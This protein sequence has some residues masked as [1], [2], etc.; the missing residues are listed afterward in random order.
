MKLFMNLHDILDQEVLE[1]LNLLDRGRQ[2]VIP[3]VPFLRR[4]GPPEGAKSSNGQAKHLQG[5]V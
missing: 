3:G 5:G 1:Q 4:L 2:T